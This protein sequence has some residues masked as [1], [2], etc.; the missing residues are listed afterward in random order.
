[1]NNKIFSK[2]FNGIVVGILILYAVEVRAQWLSKSAEKRL[3]RHVA[4][5]ASDKLEGREPGTD[6][7][8]KAARYIASEFK[9]AG[10]KPAGDSL[11]FQ[12]FELPVNPSDYKVN[13][14]LNGKVWADFKGFALPYSASGEF[15][16]AVYYMAQPDTVARVSLGGMA[17]AVEL[18]PLATHQ[19]HHRHPD[20]LDMVRWAERKGAKALI[21]VDNHGIQPGFSE[22][23]TTDKFFRTSL[24]CL[25][26]GPGLSKALSDGGGQLHLTVRRPN[27]VRSANVIGFWDN[28]APTTVVIGAHYDHL[29]RNHPGSRSEVPGQIHNGA[30]DN[31][32]GTAGLFALAR[33]LRRPEFKGNNYLFIAFTAEESGLLGSAWFVRSPLF[34]KYTFNYMLNMDMIGRLHQQLA[35]SGVGTSPVWGNNINTLRTEGFTVKTSASGVGPSD[36]TSFYYKNIPVLHFFTGL[37]EDYHKPSDDADKINYA[38]MRQVLNLILDLVATLNNQGR[39]PFEK[40]RDQEDTPT[41][42][43]KVTLGIMPDYLYDGKGIRVEGVVPGKP[44]DKAGLRGGDII[45]AIGAH[46]TP[47]MTTYMKALASFE[48]GDTTPV[49]VLRNG[50]EQVMEVEFK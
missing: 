37:H 35:I 26:A 16:G 42:R 45:L 48:K 43:F 12:Y 15:T 31:A 27:P 20:Y 34:S 47:D 49:R 40:T 24:L 21:F 33:V 14:H 11:W 17:L 23:K 25:F 32:S 7:I 18:K 41:P 5:L 46:E 9:K 28:K 29:G 3:Q 36:H 4:F 2:L 6:G 30:D 38:G 50:A 8:E 10:L 39:L 1:M 44:A 13:V 22:F 19:A